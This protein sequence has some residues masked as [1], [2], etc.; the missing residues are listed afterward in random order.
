[1]AKLTSEDRNAIA[2]YIESLP[3]RPDAAPKTK[4]APESEIN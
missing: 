4:K 1:M 2:A 3:P